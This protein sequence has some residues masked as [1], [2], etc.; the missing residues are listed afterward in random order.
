MGLLT[1]KVLRRSWCGV[2]VKV[3]IYF[4]LKKKTGNLEFSRVREREK[5][6][7]MLNGNIIIVLMMMMMF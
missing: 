3:K 7:Q 4:N 6:K 2:I 5:D 1:E